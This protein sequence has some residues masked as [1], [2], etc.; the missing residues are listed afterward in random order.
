M[1]SFVILSGRAGQVRKSAIADERK[2]LQT[3]GFADFG[4]LKSELAVADYFNF[5]PQ[6]RKFYTNIEIPFYFCKIFTFFTRSNIKCQFNVFDFKF[7]KNIS[8]VEFRLIKMLSLLFDLIAFFFV[9]M[10][11]F[12]V[13]QNNR[14]FSSLSSNLQPWFKVWLCCF[15]L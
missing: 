11:F 15:L 9:D 13:R 10:L 4:S 7:G 6:F 5:S 8:F 14:L 3:C 2:K 12:R 1:Q